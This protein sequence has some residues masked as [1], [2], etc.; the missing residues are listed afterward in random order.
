MEAAAGTGASSEQKEEDDDE[1]E[2]R[3]D[4]GDEESVQSPLVSLEEPVR[5]E[6]SEPG[7]RLDSLITEIQAGQAAADAANEDVNGDVY[8]EECEYDCGM[9]GIAGRVLGTTE[10]SFG[11]QLGGN[12]LLLYGI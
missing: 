8:G 10:S 11:R 6:V 5:R 9:E 12:H 3:D 4:I 7:K 2:Q 1:E